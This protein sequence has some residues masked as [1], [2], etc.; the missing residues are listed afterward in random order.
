MKV[1]E[2]LSVGD[3]AFRSPGDGLAPYMVD[4]FIGKSLTRDVPEEHTLS[5]EDVN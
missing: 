2:V 4:S 3:I 1:G 5:L